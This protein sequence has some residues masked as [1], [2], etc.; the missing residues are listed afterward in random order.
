MALNFNFSEYVHYAL[1]V[2]S[3]CTHLITEYAIPL[4]RAYYTLIN[5]VI[6]TRTVIGPLNDHTYFCS[7]CVHS[8]G[9]LAKA[10][11]LFKA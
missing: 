11:Q 6:I 2:Y 8:F 7:I 4:G 9:A 1:I 3:V 10:V 5:K